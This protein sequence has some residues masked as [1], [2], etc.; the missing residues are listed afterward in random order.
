MRDSTRTGATMSTLHPRALM[1]R[2][3]D[4]DRWLRSALALVYLVGLAI[5]FTWFIATHFTGFGD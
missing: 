2:S 4:K 3:A 5:F 1:R